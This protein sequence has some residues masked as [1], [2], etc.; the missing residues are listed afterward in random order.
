MFRCLWICFL[1]CASNI[2]TRTYLYLLQFIHANETE[3]INCMEVYRDIIENSSFRNIFNDRFQ[4]FLLSFILI[5]L[6]IFSTPSI[7]YLLN[8]AP[9]MKSTK[10]WYFSVFLSFAARIPRR[11]RWGKFHFDVCVWAFGNMPIECRR[12]VL[13][14]SAMFLV[15]HIKFL[16]WVLFAVNGYYP[17]Q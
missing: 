17:L 11:H 3:I 10:E 14:I 7:T 2:Y 16:S 6:F 8:I 9:K 5:Y 15:R 13:F 4:I 12:L 1:A